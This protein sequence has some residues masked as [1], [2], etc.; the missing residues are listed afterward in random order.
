[1]A[2][3]RYSVPLVSP[4][5]VY[6]SPLEVGLAVIQLGTAP[7]T[8]SPTCHSRPAAGAASELGKVPLTDAPPCKAVRSVSTGCAGLVTGR[9][10]MV[11]VVQPVPPC[12]LLLWTRTR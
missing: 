7:P 6:T 8:T 3:I 5:K 12:E 1:M 11:L 2:R 10:V 4:L 9:A